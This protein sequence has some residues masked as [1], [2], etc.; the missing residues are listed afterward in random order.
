M[1][2]MGVKCPGEN[3]SGPNEM[4]DVGRGMA[5]SDIGAWCGSSHVVTWQGCSVPGAAPARAKALRWER[6]SEES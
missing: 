4:R 6:V 5:T 2:P 3:T 1:F